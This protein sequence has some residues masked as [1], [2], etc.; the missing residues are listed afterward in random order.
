MRDTG[1]E[2]NRR[3]ALAAKRRRVPRRGLWRATV[4]GI[5]P[6]VPV[7]RSTSAATPTLWFDASGIEWE[8]YE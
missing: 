7:L 5:R 4:S 1:K 3:M 8:T 2:W 6:C